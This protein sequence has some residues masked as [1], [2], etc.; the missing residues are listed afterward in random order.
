MIAVSL[1]K[2][3]AWT[4]EALRSNTLRSYHER[5]A[6]PTLQGVTMQFFCSPQECEFNQKYKKVKGRADGDEGPMGE[7]AFDLGRREWV[8]FGLLQT[9]KELSEGREES[10]SM[11]NR[12]SS[13]KWAQRFCE[14]KGS[15]SHR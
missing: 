3:Q 5:S 8:G 13:V 11:R 9:R 15:H 7:A 10:C 4:T 2:P 12:S 14:G 1:V 6:Q